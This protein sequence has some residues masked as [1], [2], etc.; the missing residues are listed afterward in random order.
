MEFRSRWKT[1]V[2]EEMKRAQKAGPQH[3][4]TFFQK[5]SKVPSS[6]DV[7]FDLE[8]MNSKSLISVT[9]SLPL[10]G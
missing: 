5:M 7:H 8:E 3:L 9:I 6:H 1:N 4:E 2:I 10:Y